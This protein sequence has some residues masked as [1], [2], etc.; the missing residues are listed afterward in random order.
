MDS[1]KK[2]SLSLG[3]T[4]YEI[5]SNNFNQDV[6]EI[7]LIINYNWPTTHTVSAS[8]EITTKLKNDILLPTNSAFI[9]E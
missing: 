3:L 6:H 1:I 2:F 8:P 4:K 5:H 7:H 9:F